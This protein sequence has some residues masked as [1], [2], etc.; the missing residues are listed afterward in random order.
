MLPLWVLLEN[1]PETFAQ[2][3]SGVNTIFRHYWYFLEGR[4]SIGPPAM[5]ANERGLLNES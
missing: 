2:S 4:Q 3:S 1:E 5:E